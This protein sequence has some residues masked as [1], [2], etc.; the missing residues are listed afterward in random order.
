MQFYQR[1]GGVV[2]KTDTGHEN[3]QEDGVIFEFNL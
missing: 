3:K 1:M 2:T